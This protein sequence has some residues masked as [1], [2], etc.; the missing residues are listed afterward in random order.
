[1]RRQWPLIWLSALT[2][3]AA[4]GQSLITTFAGTDWLFSGDGKPGVDAS[5][6]V[7]SGVAVDRSGRVIVVDS[8]NCLVAGV[9]SDGILRVIGGSG[10]CLTT[11]DNGLATDAGLQ[12]PKSVAV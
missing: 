10:I 3:W 1:M 12:A 11:G 9:G 4:G 6:G 8:D 5:L 2:A 7:V